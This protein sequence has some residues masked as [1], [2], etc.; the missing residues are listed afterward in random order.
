MV[1]QKLQ[2]TTQITAD[3]MTVFDNIYNPRP[4]WPYYR[5]LSLLSLSTYMLT[6]IVLE[7]FIASY[8]I[9]AFETHTTER[10]CADLLTSVRHFLKVWN[11][12][13]IQFIYLYLVAIHFLHH[14]RSTKGVNHHH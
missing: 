4:L 13:K 3:M 6:M 12:E 10:K 14:Y 11:L 8:L 7:E 5:S 1:G 9:S 2:K